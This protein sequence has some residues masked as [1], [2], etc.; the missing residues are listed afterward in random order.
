MAAGEVAIDLGVRGPNFTTAS[1]CASGA[2]AIGVA[3]DLLRSGA[4]DIVLAGG[5]ESACSR[6]TATCFTRMRA[7]SR[8]RA[9]PAL[10]SRP[11][12]AQRDVAGQR[13]Q[14]GVVLGV[15]RVQRAQVGSHHPAAGRAG[16]ARYAAA[17][18]RTRHR[19]SAPPAATAR[20]LPPP[21]PGVPAPP[22]TPTGSPATL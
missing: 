13:T 1:A 20:T 15:A 10:A 2:T 5:S 9:E 19:P 17:A 8:R 6:M 16:A 3:R 21:A 4:C 18:R 7:L 14:H 11:F 12:D 22:P